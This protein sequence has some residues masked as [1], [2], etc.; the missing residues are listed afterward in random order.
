MCLK[1]FKVLNLTQVSTH[2]KNGVNAFFTSKFHKLFYTFAKV[3]KFWLASFYR[4]TTYLIEYIKSDMA[5]VEAD[6][7]KYSGASELSQNAIR[8]LAPPSDIYTR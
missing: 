3:P 2:L 5:A 7:A 4:A 6:I 8:S 1:I